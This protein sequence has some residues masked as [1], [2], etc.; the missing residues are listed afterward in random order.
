MG[1]GK[2]RFS[3]SYSENDG[4]LSVFISDAYDLPKEHFEDGTVVPGFRVLCFE[5]AKSRDY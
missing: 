5:C 3:T 1:Q 4:A 2:I